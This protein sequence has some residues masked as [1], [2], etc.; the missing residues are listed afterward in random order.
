MSRWERVAGQ[1]ICIHHCTSR[2]AFSAR[3][4]ALSGAFLST[5]PSVMD[6]GVGR[7]DIKVAGQDLG[8]PVQAGS[9]AQQ[10]THPGQFVIE[11]RPG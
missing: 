9:T 6:V 1:G 4:S 5:R 11:L 10:I 8:H 2:S 3:G 7:H